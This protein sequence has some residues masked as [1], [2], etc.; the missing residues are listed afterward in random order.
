V[1][2]DGQD[3]TEK[4]CLE[5]QNKNKTKSQT[6]KKPEDRLRIPNFEI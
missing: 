6:N 3:C 2:Q 1:F 5:K 4:P